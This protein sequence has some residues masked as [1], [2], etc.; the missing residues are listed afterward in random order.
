M[1][2]P[3]RLKTH[4]VL[5]KAPCEMVFQ[6]MSSFG[7]GRIQGD[8]NESPKV[9]ARDGNVI[10][11]EFRARA[12]AGPFTYTTIEQVTLQPSDE[13][14]TLEPSERI[15]FKHLKGPLHY[16]CEEF[17]FNDVDGDTE[18]V[19]SGEFIWHW[20]PIVGRLGGLGGLVYTKPTFER[21]IEKHMR[22]I[23]ATCEARASRSLV[24]SKRKVTQS[25]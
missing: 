18:L 16:A 21:A 24:F 12:G 4:W 11:A 10:V 3:I 20:L 22:Q 25:D 17:V 19:H 8:N 1:A 2:K 6:K 15:T 5:I 14:V 13:Q 9:I 7:R 23:Q